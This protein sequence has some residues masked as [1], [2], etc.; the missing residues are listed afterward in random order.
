[1]LV[2]VDVG[3]TFTDFVG[4]R[5]GRIVTEKVL[6]TPRE[7]ASAVTG[8]I[9]TLGATSMAHGTTVATNAIVER[10]GA[11]T[12]LVT[13]AGFE[14]LLIIGR[15]NRP[16]LYDWRVTR[17]PPVIPRGMSMGAKE[18]VGASG[19]ILKGLSGSEVRRISNALARMK[20]ESVAICLLFAFANPR[21]EESLR[22]ALGPR[23]CI[24]VSS[25][26][27]PEF[28]E[29]ERASTTALD[30]YVKPLV[31][32]HLR[33]LE[34]ALGA[35]FLV[36]KSGG[37]TAGSRQVLER[38]IDLALSGPA[39]GVSAARTLAATFRIR[40]LVTFDMGGTSSDF[41]TI[42]G[43]QPT[44]TSESTIEG[45]PL[46]LQVIDIS[47]VG[48]GGGSLAWL[49]SG[50]ALR[51]GPSSAGAEPGPMAY[52][53]GGSQPTV[54]DADLFSGLLPGAL[55]GGAMPLRRDLAEAGLGALAKAMRIPI[56]TAALGVRRVVESNMVRAM[57]AVLARRGL[58]PRRLPLLAYGGAGPVHAAFLAAEIGSP[59]VLIPFLP[60]SFSAYGILTA[61]LR[62]D[63]ASGIV[64]PLASAKAPIHKI[65]TGLRA[66]AVRDL[67]AHGVS[68][69]K[70]RFLFTA[71]LRFE[72]QSYEINVP[73]TPGMGTGFRREHRRRYGYASRTEPVEITAVRL[74]AVVGRPK[75][76]PRGPAHG[77]P[78]SRRRRVLFEDGW[79][80]SRIWRRPALHA[81]FTSRGPAIIEEDQATTAVP[82]G[83]LF[84]VLRHGVLELEAV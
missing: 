13:T 45:L 47:S 38:P 80:D 62:L 74:T 4:F 50:G 72:G 66:R 34:R 39:G 37:G 19:R 12:A 68:S 26:V 20:A 25:R 29:Y 5:A 65:A 15:Q 32:G 30:A 54:T 71:D 21:H 56:D 27:H 23:F 2:G 1:M 82:P 81:G 75:I 79:T 51:V 24:S 58:D 22:K 67:R 55:L 53:H 59:R 17:T 42:L 57:K 36:M 78:V 28:R 48:A 40:D 64:R 46:A 33:S 73:V 18:R 43:G 44:Y 84:R 77:R 41:S 63:Y 9:R 35:P 76:F 70:A 10:R 16:S 61:D 3:G 8:G 31:A 52:G 69:S 49:D 7:P 14:D 83:W 6:S 11:R 60:G